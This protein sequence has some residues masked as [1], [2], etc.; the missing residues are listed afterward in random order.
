MHGWLG[1]PVASSGKDIGGPYRPGDPRALEIRPSSTRLQPVFN[2]SSTRLQPVFNPS[3]KG[4]QALEKYLKKP[5]SEKGTKAGKAALKKVKAYG[6][7]RLE[8]VDDLAEEGY[9][10]DAM[11]LLST[12]SRSFK[13]TDVGDKA[14]A[15]HSSWKKDKK[16]KLEITVETI[17]TKT[18]EFA[19]LK[20]YKKAHA[21]LQAIVKSNKY[22][23]TKSFKKAEKLSEKYRRKMLPG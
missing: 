23:E 21:Y 10:I 9:Y 5:K 14:R 6:A 12:L 2:P 1:R 16:I 3:S 11:Q 22:A 13:G 4:I 7:E 8:A 19:R 18:E 17:I 15:K 20:Q